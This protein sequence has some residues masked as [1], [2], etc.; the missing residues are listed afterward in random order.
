MAEDEEK[1]DVN[2]THIENSGETYV[3]TAE[4]AQAGPIYSQNTYLSIESFIDAEFRNLSDAEKRE[5]VHSVVGGPISLLPSELVG[6]EIFQEDIRKAVDDAFTR[7]VETWDSE[8][9]LATS[10]YGGVVNEMYENDSDNDELKNLAEAL[11]SYRGKAYDAYMELASR[12]R[13]DSEPTKARERFKA[14]IEIFPEHTGEPYLQLA[15]MSYKAKDRHT[16]VEW[17]VKARNVEVA[18]PED[19]RRVSSPAQLLIIR[20]EKEWNHGKTAFR[21][22]EKEYDR[23]N[24]EKAW[25]CLSIAEQ[26]D[27]DLD[28]LAKPRYKIAMAYS[29]LV[30]KKG[31]ELGDLEED[32]NARLSDVV[33]RET[34]LHIAEVRKKNQE[35]KI[36]MPATDTDTLIGSMGRPLGD[37]WEMGL[38]RSGP[39]ISPFEAEMPKKEPFGLFSRIGYF[40]ANLGLALSR[41]GPTGAI[42]GYSQF[43]QTGLLNGAAIG[44]GLSVSL[45]SIMTLAG[46]DRRE[47]FLES[48]IDYTGGYYLVMGT[49]VLAGGVAS[50]FDPTKSYISDTLDYLFNYSPGMLTTGVAMVAGGLAHFL[51]AVGI[52]NMKNRK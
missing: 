40:V 38:G 17:A 6:D 25:D 24:L 50:L 2:Y 20:I 4:V 36:G 33:E 45:P 13:K 3:Q 51:L 49:G 29:K 46:K 27:F 26:M 37:M 7:D 5:R 16:A 12:D 23:G 39:Q 15:M 47:D 28:M 48:M 30:S 22:W 14:A 8:K 1:R 43:D 35:N 44:T 9:R 18:M 32:L 52:R 19:T 11:E 41:G 42:L 31:D 34:K 10:E 21:A